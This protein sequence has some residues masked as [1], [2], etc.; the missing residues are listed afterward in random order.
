M[1]RFLNVIIRIRIAFKSDHSFGNQLS[2][3]F[4]VDLREWRASAAQ[5]SRLCAD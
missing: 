5:H 1:M 3:S 4:Q 2:F